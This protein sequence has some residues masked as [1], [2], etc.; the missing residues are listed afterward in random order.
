[1]ETICDLINKYYEKFKG[2]PV[3]KPI[4]R[5]GQVNDAF[6]IVVL[7]TLYG[8]EIGIDIEK[9]SAGDINKLAS[10]IVAPPDAGIDIVVEHEDI[11]ESRF[12]FIQVKNSALSPLEREQALDY[13]EKTVLKYMKNATSVNENIRQVLSCTSLSEADKGNCNYILVHTGEDNFIN[14]QKDKQIIITAT[15][16]EVLRND[17]NAAIP[18]VS[19]ETFN[20]DS[21]NNFILYE[22]AEE[23]PAILVNIRGYDLARLAMKYTNTSLGRNILF[24]QN[25]REALSKSKTYEGM[26]NTIKTEPAKFWFYNNGI[27]VIAEDFDT[28]KTTDDKAVDEI[29]LKNFSIIN[30]A[31]TT[32]SLGRFYK[33][34]KLNNNEEEIEQLK[35]VFVLARIL[36]VEDNEFKSRIAIY[37]NT[38]NPITT[39]DMA[40]N[41]EEQLQLFNRLLKGSKPHIYME[42]RRGATPP[43]DVQL[44]KHRITSNEELAQLAFAG[45][46]RDPFTAKDKKNM[47][48]DTDYKQSEFT[49]NEYYHKIFHYNF[50]SSE[51]VLFNRSKDEID[52]L[53]FVYYLYKESKR[54]LLRIYKKRIKER[55]EQLLEPGVDRVKLEK[56]IADY[57]KLKAICNICTFYCIAYYYSFK[58][59]FASADSGLKYKYDEYYSDKSFREKQIE[60]FR[61]T[62]LTPTINVIKNLTATTPNLNTWIRDRKSSPLFLEKVTEILEIDMS[63]EEGYKKYIEIFKIPT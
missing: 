43:N 61:D 27:T 30:G 8:K 2:L 54:N 7:E 55:Q 21:F 28:K 50:D 26:A 57:E 19:K 42:I 6:E 44:Y 41:R 47:I 5:N 23:S 48:F 32:S 24:G 49:V 22:E 63:L 45:F 46:E 3:G 39:R 16:L 31:Q 52:E 36:K 37:N 34:A 4:V 51:G 13:M 60:G 20:S 25:L 35:K 62:F 58:S 40:S 18:K 29:I 14:N 12:D 9:M 59:E 10:Y 38:Q 15:E 1:M 17:A 11:D 56:S 53:L 33:E